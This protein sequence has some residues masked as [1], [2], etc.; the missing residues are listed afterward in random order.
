MGKKSR[1]RKRRGQQGFRDRL[2]LNISIKI[3]VGLVVATL[4]LSLIQCTV[5]KPQSPTW[6]TQLIVPLANRTMDMA[7]LVE[8]IDDSSL[9]LDS[10]G[11]P[12]FSFSQ[13]VD[14]LS[15]GTS[16]SAPDVSQSVTQ[17]LGSVDV[18]PS[19]IAPFTA[20]FTDLSVFPPGAIPG[21]PIDFV[22]DG[23]IISEFGTITVG[24]GMIYAIVTNNLDLQLDTLL[25][26]LVDMTTFT[27]IS[28]GS[29][30]GGLPM[31]VT[32][33]IQI[34]LS[35]KTVGNRFRLQ[36]HGHTVPGVLLS[37]SGKSITAEMVFP[38]PLQVLSG[39]AI[40]AET[41]IS[42]SQTAD[43]VSGNIIHSATLQSGTLTLNL[44]NGT[45]LAM[46]LTLT[47]PELTS[48]GTPLTI[49]QALGGNSNVLLEVNISGYVLQPSDLVAPQSID[50]NINGR[51]PSSSP[52]LVTINSADSISATVSLTG[53]TFAT[54]SGVFDS[55]TTTFSPISVDIGAPDGFDSAQFTAATL[56]LE[57]ENGSG[58]SGAL[59]LDV[60]GSNGKSLLING[61]VAAGSQSSPIT[62]Y[63]TDTNLA[64]FLNPIPASIAV[65][66]SV[67]FGDGVTVTEV[68]G[69]D[70]LKAR[71]RIESPLEVR[72]N[73][74]VVELD[75]QATS[76]D[77]ADITIITDH[78]ISAQLD[79][80]VSNHLPAGVEV[81]V[82]ISADSATLYSAPELTIGP[83]TV[84][85][86]LI[87]GAG[88][89]IGEVITNS[90]ISLDSAD[91][92]ALLHDTLYIG[93]T[94]E[95]FGAGGQSVRFSG[96]DYITIEAMATI[97]Y[98]F[99]GNF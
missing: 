55:V 47:V 59:S 5:K 58:L 20:S 10:S 73:N 52:N 95:I 40:I 97:E 16:M 87:N 2:A 24:N 38:V 42:F 37:T 6:N 29:L 65:S 92:Q 79:V 30:L 88:I 68:T 91:V 99:N 66:G 80:T 44:S 60:Q 19:P 12:F 54:I 81:L 63:I 67:T 46:D 31:G 98:K 15:V 26:D 70:F 82:Y 90:I 64:D 48:G 3:G 50:L 96:S 43:I 32:D 69:L 93:Q 7:E 33:T 11:N 53:L 62:S 61:V 76:V 23:P 36:V 84:A 83:I 4:F 49:V 75:P 89:A 74:S 17:Q 85:S 94:L 77:T 56:T 13:E 39:T 14:S 78:L 21:I 51:I 27:I 71:I 57:I 22:L 34:P 45:L 72:F 8:R 86:A 41:N 18:T 28:S 25:I 1:R 35:G 9:T